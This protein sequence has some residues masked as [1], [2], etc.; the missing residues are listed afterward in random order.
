MEPESLG[1][2]TDDDV[3]DVP[4]DDAHGVYGD[5]HADDGDDD[6]CEYD[7][8]QPSY[9]RPHQLQSWEMPSQ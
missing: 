1:R 5:G 7:A 3:H 8:L 4:R 2:A 9:S 6:V